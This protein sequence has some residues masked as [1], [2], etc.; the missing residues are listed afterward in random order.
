VSAYP[1]GVRQIGYAYSILTEFGKIGI[2]G[3]AV[4]DKVAR[5]VADV[6]TDKDYILLNPLTLS[7]LA[8]PILEGNTVVGVLNLECDRQDAFDQLDEDTVIALADFAAIALH[9]SKER[10]M[11]PALQP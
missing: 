4:L 7:E 1:H 3:R 9:N 5:R 2:T 10:M 11:D 6:R 8:V